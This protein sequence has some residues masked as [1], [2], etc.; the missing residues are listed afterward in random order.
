MPHQRGPGSPRVVVDGIVGRDTLYEVGLWTTPFRHGAPPSCG[1]SPSLISGDRTPEAGRVAIH[2]AT[3]HFGA[4]PP[5]LTEWLRQVDRWIG[6][7]NS[8]VA[9]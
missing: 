5:P 1:R 6:Y 7:A 9:E 2:G 3:L 8:V 4:A